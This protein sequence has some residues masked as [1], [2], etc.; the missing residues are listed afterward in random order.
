MASIF[1][2]NF[3]SKYKLPIIFLY[4]HGYISKSKTFPW[5]KLD[6]IN[7]SLYNDILIYIFYNIAITQQYCKYTIRIQIF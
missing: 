3:I 4:E 6:R 5:E 7:I 1:S 2:S